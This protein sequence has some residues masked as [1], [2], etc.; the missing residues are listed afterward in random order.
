MKKTFLS[1]MG[2]VMLSIFSSSLC[3]AA[4]WRAGKDTYRTVCSSCHKT[5]GEAG[6]LPLDS[7]TRAEWTAFLAQEPTSIH[8]NAW[9]KLDRDDIVSL[10]LYFKKH[11]KDVKELRGCG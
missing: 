9:K 2:L 5:R 4:D 3:V 10:E 7:K 8:Q 11:A 6:R 1:F